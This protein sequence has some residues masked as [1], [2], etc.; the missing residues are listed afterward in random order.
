MQEVLID[1]EST[2]RKICPKDGIL[3]S[4]TRGRPVALRLTYCVCN[5]SLLF[6]LICDL[7]YHSK[8]IPVIDFK[9]MSISSDLTVLTFGVGGQ[10]GT[11]RRRAF[12]DGGSPGFGAAVNVESEMDDLMTLSA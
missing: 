6:N 8:T 3:P 12:R 9:A 5:D 7:A 10:A 4:S 1:R 11:K 2:G